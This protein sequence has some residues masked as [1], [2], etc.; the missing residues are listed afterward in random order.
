MNLF[1]GHRHRVKELNQGGSH[2]Q[3]N[4]FGGPLD[5]KMQIAPRSHR[6]MFPAND[7]REIRQLLW[8]RC[9]KTKPPPRIIPDSH[10]TTRPRKGKSDRARIVKIDNKCTD[11]LKHC[12]D[13]L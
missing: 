9:R 7:G 2:I 3:T 13:L 4:T 12:S 11:P 8:K 1:Y 10:H 5:M 6:H